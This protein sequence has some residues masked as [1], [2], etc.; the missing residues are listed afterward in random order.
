MS[1]ALRTHFGLP[2]RPGES[3][4][5][6]DGPRTVGTGGVEGAEV[7]R[8]V[9]EPRPETG[10][11]A[12]GT[13]NY[14]GRPEGSGLVVGQFPTVGRVCDAEPGGGAAPAAHDGASVL[15]GRSFA[16]P[17]AVP[18]QLVRDQQPGG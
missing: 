11:V 4:C 8:F 15:D 3:R 5:L 10:S 16:F 18:A 17:R 12:T 9:V 14:L 1:A 7:V 6:A 13:V 2:V